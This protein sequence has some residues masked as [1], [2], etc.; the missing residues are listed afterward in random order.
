MAVVGIRVVRV[1][2]RNPLMRVLVNVLTCCLTL[3]SMN[4]L[5]VFVMNV[6]MGV[7]LAFMGMNMSM[8]L[9]KVQPCSG[10]H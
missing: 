8:M 10:G 5:V 6:S 1:L 3:R 2:V 4:M 9:G 7:S